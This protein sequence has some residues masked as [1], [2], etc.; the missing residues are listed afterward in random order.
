ML[1]GLLTLEEGDQ[2]L[3]FVR[4]FYGCPST[5]IW[6]D[7]MGNIHEV[8]QEEGGE[9]GDP[10]MPALFSLAPHSVGGCSRKIVRRGGSPCPLG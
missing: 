7:D 10:L 1:Q 9:Q 4:Q 5:H 2:I 3:P 8:A 6:E